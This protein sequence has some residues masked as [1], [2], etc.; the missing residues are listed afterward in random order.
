MD[1]TPPNSGC[2]HADILEERGLTLGLLV[3][4]IPL[5][6][7]NPVKAGARCLRHHS[8]I[9]SRLSLGTWYH[10]FIRQQFQEI[11]WGLTVAAVWAAA[12]SRVGGFENIKGQ[13]LCR[14]SAC[15]C[16]R[17]LA[18]WRQD[19]QLQDLPPSRGRRADEG[20]HMHQEKGKRVNTI[21]RWAG[22]DHVPMCDHLAPLA[23]S[24]NF[25][26]GFINFLGLM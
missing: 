3:L 7:K 8:G 14:S 5:G 9:F 11:Q 13:S 25:E 19:A 15:C 21:W 12:W 26:K 4:R 23:Q 6:R 1:G 16:W 2:R 18:A 17:V 24:G 22:L 10:N 20:R